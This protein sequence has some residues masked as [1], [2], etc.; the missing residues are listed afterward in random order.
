MKTFKF[1]IIAKFLYR[2]SFIPIASIMLFYI[3][4]SASGI[5]LDVMNVLPMLINIL[6]LYVI[7]RFYVKS[8]AQFPF[9]IEVTEE[10][11]ICKNFK[12]GKDGFE[13]KFA[14]IKNIEGG[15]FENKPTKALVIYAEGKEQSISISPHMKN[16]NRLLTL[17][18]SRINK[19]M[20]DDLILKVR[21]NQKLPAINKMSG[22][23][24]KTSRKKKK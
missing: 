10:K 21:E 17:I 7:I 14:D 20:Y 23:I 12:Y 22:K 9:E 8:Y 4:V 15:V 11:L 18:L 13:I 1:S 5:H 19:N 3:V 24:K 2:Y 16:Y 6:F